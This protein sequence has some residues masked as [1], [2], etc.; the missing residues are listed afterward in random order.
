MKKILIVLAILPLLV[1]ICFFIL[2]FYSKTVKNNYGIIEDELR[3]CPESPNCVSSQDKKQTHYIEPIKVESVKSSIQILVN[4][5]NKNPSYSLQQVS[6]N[7]LHVI[8][9]SK[10]FG[11]RDDVEF[12]GDPKNN[13]LHVR[14][15]SRVGRSDLNANRKRVENLRE[16]LEKQLTN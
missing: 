6:N 2:G 16:V 5:F 8:F 13:L 11:F 7:Y 4:H 10:I 1:L 12:F 15:A 14:S 3:P 9:K